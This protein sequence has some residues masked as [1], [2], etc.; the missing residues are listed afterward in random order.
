MHM[1]EIAFD[2]YRRRDAV[3]GVVF[4]QFGFKGFRLMDA[5]IVVFYGMD[6][7]HRCFPHK[8]ERLNSCFFEV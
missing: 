2:L 6:D 1:R 5:K 3:V 7:I 4:N 8:K